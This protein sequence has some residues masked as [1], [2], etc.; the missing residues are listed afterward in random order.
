MPADQGR[1]EQGSEYRGEEDFLELVITGE[2][3]LLVCPQARS[4][5]ASTS[6]PSHSEK[7]ITVAEGRSPQS[8]PTVL[9]PWGSLCGWSAS[10]LRFYSSLSRWASSDITEPS[11][12]QKV[13]SLCLSSLIFILRLLRH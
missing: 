8:Y 1:K 13:V 9:V 10:A 6:V 4:A 5:A 2:T 7:K 12:E 11:L 3:G